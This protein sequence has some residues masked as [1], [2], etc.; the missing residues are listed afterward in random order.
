MV[1]L[2]SRQFARVVGIAALT[3]AAAA[4][5]VNS[6]W[7]SEKVLSGTHTFGQVAAACGS[8]G[9]QFTVAASGGYGCI[10]EKTGVACN[11][12]GQCTAI[13]YSGKCPAIAKG[14]N[15]VLRPPASAGTASAAVGTG[16]KNK[17]PL[18]NV[19]Q[20]VVVQ[21]SGGAHSGGSK[22]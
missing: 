14:L 16:S 8:S 4:F 13:C 10:G 22:H 2:P 12:K 5:L 20:P 11:A 21:R 15:G 17:P 1:I 3:C 9:G 19:N 18:H 7:A 6:A